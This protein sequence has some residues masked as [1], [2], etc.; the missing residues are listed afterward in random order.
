LKIDDL[1]KQGKILMEKLRLGTYPLAIKMIKSEKEI[2]ENAYRPLK[3]SGYHLDVCQG[4]AKSRWE[5]KTVAMLKED[6]WCFETVIGY[7]LAEAPEDFIKGYNRYPE[8]ALNEEA[9]RRGAEVVPRFELNK[10]IGVVSAPLNSCNFE[11]D[12]CIIYSTPA[13]LTQLL[14]AKNAIDGED[15]NC[16]LSGHDACIYAVVPVL[17]NNKCVVASPCRGDRCNAMTQNNEIIFSAPVSMLND[18]VISL[19]HLENNDWGFPWPFELRPERELA[20]N[21]AKIGRAIGIKC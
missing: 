4:F 11:P 7:G 20:D 9:G 14:I 3:D 10:Y 1:N 5:G 8:C 18:L 17:K 15:V 16:N 6:M 2:P 19:N 12:L 13:Q 21:Y